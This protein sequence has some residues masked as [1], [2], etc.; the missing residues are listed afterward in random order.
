MTKQRPYLVLVW[1]IEAFW[2]ERVAGWV[3]WKREN[4]RLMQ[5]VDDRKRAERR[6]KR[7]RGGQ[8]AD[9]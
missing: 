7:A 3:A 2:R 5:E 9:R 4:R 1:D 6:A 8:H